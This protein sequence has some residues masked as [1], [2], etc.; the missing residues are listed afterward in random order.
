MQYN[1]SGDSIK[2]NGN[3]EK[4]TPPVGRDGFQVSARWAFFGGSRLLGPFERTCDSQCEGGAC[5]AL[6][7]TGGKALR[8]GQVY[9]EKSGREVHSLKIDILTLFP[10]LFDSWISHSMIK[11]AIE[12]KRVTIQAH[13]LRDFTHDRHRT[14]DDKPFGG[15]PGML[16]KP[17]PIFEAADKILKGKRPKNTRFIYMTPQGKPLDQAT[18]RDR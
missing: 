13:D 9:F 15:G 16:L 8:N 5:A 12:K 6:D 14:C 10:G 1:G 2:N 11:R 7:E 18:A 17:E 3:K 4:D